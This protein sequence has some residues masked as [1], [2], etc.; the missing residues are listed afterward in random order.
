VIVDSLT[1]DQLIAEAR[2]GNDEALGLLLDRYRP[3]LRLLAQR[4]LGLDVQARVDPSDVVQRACLDVHRDWG[5]F[6]GQAEAELIAWLRRIL[7]NNAVETL[8]EHV[9]AKKRS[10]KKEQR[11]TESADGER[12]LANVLEA[13]QSSPS[14]RAMRGEA[15]IRLAQALETLPDDQ[16]EAIRLRYLEGWSLTD[17][18]RRLDRSGVAVAGLLK[19]GL[20]G[21]RKHFDSESETDLL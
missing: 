20:R 18:A 4:R 8:Q 15:A 1:P 17:I 7:E 16:R 11:L 9:V 5:A 13:D 6:R 3:Y 14:Q 2:A 10:T 21:L 12:P 19:R